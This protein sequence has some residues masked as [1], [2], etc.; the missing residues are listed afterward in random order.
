MEGE[1][2]EEVGRQ[3]QPSQLRWNGAITTQRTEGTSTK[4]KLE[5]KEG[6]RKSVKSVV[7]MNDNEDM[8]KGPV[9]RLQKCPF[10]PFS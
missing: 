2:D 8:R 6:G 7:I 5:A 1:D 4:K 3:Q 9:T 10:L